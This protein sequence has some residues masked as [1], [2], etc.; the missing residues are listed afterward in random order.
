MSNAGGN[1]RTKRPASANLKTCTAL[2]L[3]REVQFRHRARDIWEITAEDQSLDSL[4][5]ARR[6]NALLLEV[7]WRSAVYFSS[8]T[9]T[10]AATNRRRS[11]QE[12]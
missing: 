11:I 5:Q 2:R 1:P 7:G 9:S 6:L 8:A 10:K 3:L 12:E 4:E